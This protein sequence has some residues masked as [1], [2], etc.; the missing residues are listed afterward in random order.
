MRGKANGILEKHVVEKYGSVDNFLTSLERG[1]GC[2]K[3]ITKNI[4]KSP[5][6][7]EKMQL[8]KKLCESLRIDFEG[9]FARENISEADGAY[10]NVRHSGKNLNAESA[11]EKYSLMNPVAQRK[12]LEYIN[13]ILNS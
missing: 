8:G 7:M 11:E 10:L 6:F 9:L 13:N 5:N 2:K 4:I 12:T 1:A 3:E